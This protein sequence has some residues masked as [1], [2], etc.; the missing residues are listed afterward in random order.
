MEKKSELI[1]NVTADTNKLVLKIKAATKHLSALADELESID[2]GGS[3]EDKMCKV[4]E[5]LGELEDEHLRQMV[6]Y[7][8]ALDVCRGI[9]GY[10][11]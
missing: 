9:K 6:D 7:V 2:N 11:G 5:L 8:E 1:I 3:S 4:I 10:G